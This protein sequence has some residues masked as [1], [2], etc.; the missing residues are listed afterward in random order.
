M[1]FTTNKST[2]CSSSRNY[3]R[4]LCF[5]KI[6]VQMCT[7]VQVSSSHQGSDE[8]PVE[9]TASVFC[10]FLWNDNTTD[11]IKVCPSTDVL[12]RPMI[13]F[14]RMYYW[15]FSFLLFL[16]LFFLLPQPPWCLSLIILAPC[17][18]PHPDLLL[19]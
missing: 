17:D 19:V 18:I 9:D 13:G 4:P 7:T 10:S 11:C 5:L 12:F 15:W 8:T 6:G 16:F 2:V 3:D 1:I 14:R